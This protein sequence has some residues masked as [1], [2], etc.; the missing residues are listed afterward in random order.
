M[1]KLVEA[2]ILRS[3]HL[4]VPLYCALLFVI[5]TITLDFF[6]VLFG[7]LATEQL[8]DHIIVALQLLDITMIANLIWLIS[9]GSFYV[10]VDSGSAHEERPPC[11]Q[12]VSSGILKQKMAGSLIG[13]S[14]V[15]LL[16]MFL[17]MSEQTEPTDLVKLAVLLAI[18]LVFILGLLV[19]SYTNE[20][21]SNHA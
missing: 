20:R 9:A 13:V 16:Q 8:N 2:V 19:F 11:L 3:R 6:R 4:L 12:H 17:H 18:H 1:K 5:L 21:L 10:F 15:H 7:T 14:S